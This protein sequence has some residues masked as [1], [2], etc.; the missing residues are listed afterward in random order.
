MEVEK[1]IWPT[2]FKL[3]ESGEKT[4]EVRLAD[5]DYK[6]G[7]VLILREWDPDKN[8]Y[9]GRSIRKTITYVMLTKNIHYWPDDEIEAKGLAV[10]GLR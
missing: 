10:M 8:E 9:T 1:K 4:F 7:D 6:P 2:F 5:T 3:I